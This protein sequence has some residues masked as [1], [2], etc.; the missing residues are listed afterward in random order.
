MPKTLACLMV[1]SPTVFSWLGHMP[2][3][4]WSVA[5]LAEVR[6]LDRIV[7]AVLPALADRATRL[8]AEQE[9]EVVAVPKAFGA[10]PA[11]AAVDKWLT[12]ATGPGADAD[13]VAVVKPTSP[14]LPAGKIEACL[15]AVV[16]NKCS[17]CYPARTASALVAAR[18]T[19]VKEAVESVRVF[20]V[21]VPA[22]RAAVHT[23]TV[24]LL[25]SLNVGVPDEFVLAD[26]LVTANKV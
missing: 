21:N 15:T 7:C 16:R 24:S 14:F 6:G 3:M 22:E 26:A 25:E 2:I 1:T 13:V 17:L 23:V 10:E 9:I 4:N 12:S 8:L 18:R 5:Q 20:R 19:T 11:D